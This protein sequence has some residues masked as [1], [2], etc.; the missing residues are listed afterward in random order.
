[1]TCPKCGF[2]LPELETECQ[3]CARIAAQA[4]TPDAF[5]KPFA[6][7][8]YL[9]PRPT[10]TE[11]QASVAQ[12]QSHWT[13]LGTVAVIFFCFA[14]VLYSALSSNQSRADDAALA[15]ANLP[16]PHP[17]R[18]FTPVTPPPIY[19]GDGSGQTH[20]TE[21]DPGPFR[22]P[23]AIYGINSTDGGPATTGISGA[24]RRPHGVR[25][26]FVSDHYRHTKSGRL[27]H[28]HSYYRRH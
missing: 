15:E 4:E 20:W 21:H 14:F 12:R 28:V 24:G 13:A 27:V 11:I 25:D 9:D 17:V 19:L 7:P 23:P 22:A 3:R 16:A 2:I 8:A 1:M 6:G 18:P 10:S 5:R 26:Q